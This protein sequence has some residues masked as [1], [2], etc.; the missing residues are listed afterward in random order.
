MALWDE[1]RHTL[2]GLNEQSAY[3]L[4]LNVKAGKYQTIRLNTLFRSRKYDVVESRTIEVSTL[5]IFKVL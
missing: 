3:V 1:G 2:H 4:C 5:T